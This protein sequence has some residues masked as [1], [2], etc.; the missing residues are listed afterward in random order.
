MQ[1]E[2]LKK[3]QNINNDEDDSD[4][5]KSSLMNDIYSQISDEEDDLEVN[6]DDN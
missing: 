6:D 3:Q 1:A 4:R 5:L 2:N